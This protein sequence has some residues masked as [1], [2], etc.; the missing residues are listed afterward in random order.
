[1]EEEK[2]EEQLEEQEEVKEESSEVEEKVEEEKEPEEKPTEEEKE[3]EEEPPK[4]EEKP[5]EEESP[6]E[7]EKPEEEPPKE[8]EKE[9][10]EEPLKEEE[11]PAEEEK[12][13]EETHPVEEKKEEEKKAE[14]KPKKD[15]DKWWKTALIIATI[16][17]I[18]LLLLRCC[19][20][21]KKYKITLHY[22]DDTVIVDKGFKLAD[23]QVE[24]GE[25]SFLVDS[26]GNVINPGDELKPGGEY[27]GHIIPAG[28]E[29]VKVTYI[30][31]T[32]SFTV[33]YKKG[34]GLLF[35]KDPKKTGYVFLGWLDKDTK[36]IPTYMMPVNHDMT[37]IAIFE[38]SKLE[39]GKC[40]ENCDT[41]GDGKCTLNCD[42]NG[43][44]K[45]DKNCDTNGDGKPDTNVTPSGSTKCTLNC[46]TNGD[47]KCDKNCDTNGDGKPDK[48]VTPNGD[49]VCTLNCDS[50]GD[51]KCDANC[52]TD[53]DGQADTSVTPGFTLPSNPENSGD[54]SNSQSST[55]SD[56][57]C[58]LNCD[59]DRDGTADTNVDKDGDGIA[60]TNVDVDHDG[61]C[62]INCDTNY[63]GA[64]DSNCEQQVYPTIGFERNLYLAC[65][66]KH[67]MIFGHKKENIIY[68]K[69]NG[70]NV[71]PDYYVQG[72][73]PIFDFEKYKG[74]GKTIKFE[75]KYIQADDA[76]EK[77]YV[78]FKATITFAK[79]C[80]SNPTPSA[81]P[82]APT[83]DT[84]KTDVKDTPAPSTPPEDTTDYGTITLSA[85]NTCIAAYGEVTVTAEVSNAKDGT[86]NWS[87]SECVDIHGSGNT[88]TAIL[89]GCG[90][91]PTITGTLNN[92]ASATLTFT[93]EE[94]LT[95]W[96]TNNGSPL[97]PEDGRYFGSNMRFYSNIPAYFRGGN[98]DGDGDTLRTSAHQ[99]HNW[100]GIVTITTPCGQT[101]TLDTQGVVN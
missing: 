12:K 32:D 76:G 41:K 60:D 19:G 57:Y 86:I 67:S 82:T 24:G 49:N 56:N 79:G 8:E 23:L 11:K 4:E 37:I 13:E 88:V 75:A 20:N 87:S 51:G 99:Q 58:V 80:T 64:C 59:T 63:D 35:P 52:D 97:E 50:N 39:N 27:S 36:K 14:E 44:G 74:S 34:A 92:G 26:D 90:S 72:S 93:F 68:T 61:K 85:S 94:G 48:N 30:I 65:D 55:P 16:I 43:D 53:G 77:Y 91:N 66:S 78:I 40:K 1:M 29:T 69:I 28:K 18:I 46:D 3:V 17:I 2:K 95:Y 25:V 71:T 83:Q 38:K 15:K 101:A 7:E 100:G 96:V 70:K 31:D 47:G 9:A 73:I 84:D 54:G 45:C 81:S 22:G 98:L 5:A 6:K 21:G 62:D 89:R 10:E 33:K 42:T